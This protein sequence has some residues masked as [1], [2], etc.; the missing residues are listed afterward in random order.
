MKYLKKFEGFRSPKFGDIN[1]ALEVENKYR[2]DKDNFNEDEFLTELGLSDDE[3]ASITF[4]TSLELG[5]DNYRGMS[6]DEFFDLYK[7]ETIV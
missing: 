5:R 4:W 1:L 6:D 7:K 2:K 3:M